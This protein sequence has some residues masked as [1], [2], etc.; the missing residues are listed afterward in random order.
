MAGGVEDDVGFAM[1]SGNAIDQVAQGQLFLDLVLRNR[2]NRTILDRFSDLG[3]DDWWLTAGCLAQS[4]WNIL[5]NRPVEDRIDD[6][7]LFY[8]DADI[9]WNAEDKVIA[10]VADLFSDL[11][12]RIEIR[13]QARVPI[14]YRKKFDIEYGDVSAACEGID[15][16]AY[17]TTAIGLRKLH[18]E[19]RIYAPFGLEAVLEGTI[20]PNPVLPLRDVYVAKVIRWR[21]NW[22]CLKVMPWPDNPE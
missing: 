8:F 2:F 20:I 7:D 18:D 15:R 6:Y 21:K 16:F 9:R 17:R 11:P 22:P 12:I 4:I 3:I 13:N 1:S 5:A 14:W 10:R 19:Y